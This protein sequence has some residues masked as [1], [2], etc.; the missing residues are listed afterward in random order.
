MGVRRLACAFKAAASRR[1]PLVILV[2]L[3]LSALPF[4]VRAQGVRV[5]PDRTVVPSG[6]T[7]TVRIVLQGR[8]DD[9]RGPE[10]ADFTVVGKSSG[11][12]ISIVNGVTSQEQYV[13]LELAPRRTGNLTI[14]PVELLAGGKVVASSKPVMI[15]VSS[16]PGTPQQPQP[17]PGQPPEPA[18]AAEPAP[19]TPSENSLEAYANNPL[20]LAAR[21]PDRPV[22]AGEPVIVEYVLYTRSN[23]PLAGLRIEAAPKLSGFVVEQAR[24]QEG[25]G[26]RVLIKGIA[27]DARVQWR[28]A[29]TALRPGSAV[30]DSMTATVVVGDFFGRRNYRATSTPVSMDFKPVPDTGRPADYV[31]GTVGRFLVRASLDRPFVGLGESSVLT[32]EITGTGNLVGVKVPA[33][34]PVEGLRVARV[35]GSDLDDIRVDVGGISGKRNFQY[36]ISADKEGE[37]T[38][39]RIELPFFDPIAG[40]YD[41]SRTDPLRLVVKG[42]G[43]SGPVRE[44]KGRTGGVELAIV[45][46]PLLASPPPPAERTQDTGLLLPL[47]GG[48]VLAFGASEALARRRR[49]RAG[50]AAAIARKRSLKT[51]REALGRLQTLPDS[52]AFW[53]GVDSVLRGFV[54]DRFGFGVAGMTFEDLRTFLLARGVPD[55]LA[56]RTLAELEG[57]AFGRFAPTAAMDQD[58]SRTLERVRRLL[59]ELDGVPEV[60]R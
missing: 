44:V 39:G 21:P 16:G 45:E 3:A 35:P 12:S 2:A 51:A 57:A 30:L 27:F 23:L 52:E 10:L 5:I 33:L 24:V 4:A 36:L 56:D 60:Q 58:R 53:A 31:E 29:V 28:G 20:F 22:Y 17:P 34:Q 9:T 46:S 18:P 49:Y 25:E 50:H 1:T 43:G 32:V 54:Q 13:N 41:R 7:L 42:R 55:A 40:K 37:F 11:S 48:P 47:L 26:R 6:E 14:G 59:A 19:V 15:R 8:F 38:L